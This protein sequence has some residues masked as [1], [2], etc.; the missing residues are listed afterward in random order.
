MATISVSNFQRVNIE[1]APLDPWCLGHLH[2]RNTATSREEKEGGRRPKRR[3][4]QHL[5]KRTIRPPAG[6][7]TQTTESQKCSRDT[8]L[9]SSVCSQARTAQLMRLLKNCVCHLCSP[10]QVLSFGVTH[11]SSMVVLSRAF[12]HEDFLFISLPILP[13]NEDTQYIPHICKLFQSTSSA[14]KNHSGVKTC[15][16]VETRAQQL[17]QK[18][19]PEK[20]TVSRI[21]VYSGDLNQ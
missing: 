4:K 5:P 19:P 11:V 10:K 6:S 1:H 12:L 17:P 16:V 14:I 9:C 21:E 7:N 20:D 18:T 13:H 3:R 2:R 15:R 8:N